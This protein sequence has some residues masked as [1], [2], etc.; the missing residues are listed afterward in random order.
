MLIS[1]HGKTVHARP[2]TAILLGKSG[3]NIWVMMSPTGTHVQ[4]CRLLEKKIRR[5]SFYTAASILK[6]AAAD[7]YL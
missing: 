7:F 5:A 1:I 2:R 6:H 3:V 4:S